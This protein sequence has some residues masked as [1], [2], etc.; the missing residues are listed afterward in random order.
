MRTMLENQEHVGWRRRTAHQ[1]RRRGS[2]NHEAEQKRI[3]K[4]RLGGAATSTVLT[5]VLEGSQEKRERGRKL[6]GR[7]QAARSRTPQTNESKKV[8]TKTH[9]N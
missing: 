6:W 2:G 5:F 4:R 1:T 9:T 7:K 3:L 8:Y